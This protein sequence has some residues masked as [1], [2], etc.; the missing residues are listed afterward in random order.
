MQI[1]ILLFLALLLVHTHN[2]NPHRNISTISNPMYFDY[3]SDERI[4][5]VANKSSF[6]WYNAMTGKQIGIVSYD[7]L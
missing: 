1:L 5:G 7:F 4:L 3:S 2:L 6:A